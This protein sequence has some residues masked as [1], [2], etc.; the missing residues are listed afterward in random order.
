MGKQKEHNQAS[1]PKKK[2][3]KKKS[4]VFILI[5]ISLL[6]VFLYSAYH[7][8]IYGVEYFNN[9]RVTR[10]LQTIF[11]DALANAENDSPD[12]GEYGGYGSY[13]NSAGRNQSAFQALQQVNAEIRAWI[14]IPETNIDYPV[15]QYVDDIRYLSFNVYGRRNAN[16]AI[17]MDYRNDPVNLTQNTILYGHNMNN[18]TM[19]QN[20]TRFR[21]ESF[22][23]RAR[24][25]RFST[26]NRT[27]TGEI[28]AV[29]TIRT[30][31]D[32]FD[33]IQT[34]FHSDEA[35]AAY[36][37]EVS[38]R[39]MFRTDVVVTAQDRILTLSTCTNVH[40]DERLV[41][42]ARLVP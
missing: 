7:I 26:V 3:K 16:G 41:V 15:V 20:L 19:F 1:I 8:G 9:R 38:R 6:S 12:N 13:N 24:T 33:Y 2:K 23:R 40:A 14:T 11:H 32:R 4:I 30:S 37:E 21:Q 42:V 17:F 22:F 35:F 31:E 18:R 36:L 27:Y 28:F 29:Y 10:G 25:L 5:Q 34:V 39:N